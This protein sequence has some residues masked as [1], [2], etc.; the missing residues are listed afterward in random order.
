MSGLDS[1]WKWITT[2]IRTRPG[3]L[4]APAPVALETDQGFEDASGDAGEW[5][6]E[7]EIQIHPEQLAGEGPSPPRSPQMAPQAGARNPLELSEWQKDP[8]EKYLGCQG[9]GPKG[10]K[11]SRDARSRGSKELGSRDPGD[12]I[13]QR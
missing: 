1:L 7:E 13:N 10:S 6:S 5:G 12:P 8:E 9:S 4:E 3:R 11:R 2:P